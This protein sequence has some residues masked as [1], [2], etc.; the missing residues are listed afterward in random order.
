MKVRAI[1]GQPPCPV[2]NGLIP[3]DGF[4]IPPGLVKRLAALASR[5]MLNPSD[6]SC[7]VQTLLIEAELHH[8]E[9]ENVPT[10]L[11]SP[12]VLALAGARGLG[13]TVMASGIAG[14]Y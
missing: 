1:G 10:A 2:D 8:A 3:T 13:G 11:H 4:G 7:E 5:W 9:Q 6:G 12:G 14:H